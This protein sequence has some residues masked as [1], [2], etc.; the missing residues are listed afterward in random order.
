MT[1]ESSTPSEISPPFD[2]DD[3]SAPRL[4][5]MLANR[6]SFALKDINLE[7]LIFFYYKK[8]SSKKMTIF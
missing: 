4:L 6:R 2:R 8:T 7:K 3:A 1:S 5:N